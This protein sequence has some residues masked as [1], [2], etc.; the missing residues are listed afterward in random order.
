MNK[1]TN[2]NY[3]IKNIVDLNKTT[4]NFVK[5]KSPLIRSTKIDL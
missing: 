5:T 3:E 2:M 4:K 1:S